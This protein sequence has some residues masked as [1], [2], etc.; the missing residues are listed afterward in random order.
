M[1]EWGDPLFLCCGGRKWLQ[2]EVRRQHGG[3][4]PVAG[5]TDCGVAGT[6]VWDVRFLKEGGQ[7][8]LRIFI[9][10]PEGSASR[11]ARR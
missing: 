11:T 8:Y 10:K 2:K 1:K 7:W 4:G 6:D 9:D 3:Y 5:R